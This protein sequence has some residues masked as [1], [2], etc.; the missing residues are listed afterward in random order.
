MTLVAAQLTGKGINDIGNHLAK[1]QASFNSPP[2]DSVTMVKLRKLRKV[3]F[4]VQYRNASEGIWLLPLRSFD[5][6]T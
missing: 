6:L 4:R 1:V 2:T 5:A 3:G